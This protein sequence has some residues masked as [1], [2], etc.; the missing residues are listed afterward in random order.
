MIAIAFLA[1][2]IWPVVIVQMFKRMSVERAL[3]WSLMLGY[4]FLPPVIAIDL[5][6][7][8][9]LDK[10]TIP[11]ITAFTCLFM[12]GHK[13]TFLLPNPIARALLIAFV[14]TPIGTVMTNRE[15]ILFANGTFLPG[16]QP[17]DAISMVINQGLHLLPLFMGQAVLRSETALKEL[18]RAFFIGGMIYAIPVLI[19]VRLAPQLNTWIYGFFQHS[20]DQMMRWGGFRP[21][22]FLTHALWVALFILM[23]TLAALSLARNATPQDRPRYVAAAV[24]LMVVLALCK[25]L[26]S[27]VYL[28]MFAPVMLLAT[29]KTMIAI[30]TIIAGVMLLYPILRGAGYVPVDQIVDQFTRINA[31]RAG[32]LAFRLENEGLLLEHAFQ[33]PWFGWGGWDRNFVLD[34]NTG[35]VM[36]IADGQWVIIIGIFGWAGYIV[37]FGLLTL[38]VF[39]LFLNTRHMQNSDVSPWL[40]TLALM[41]GINMLDMLPNATLIPLTWLVCG[42]L[43][44]YLKERE[45]ATAP[46]PLTTAIPVARRTLI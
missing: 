24:F 14:F 39:L 6:L 25:S 28:L 44:G 21:I 43:L 3:I 10:A 35:R 42:A 34:P 12:L 5:P 31:D 27:L 30:A 8:P 16:L 41:H 45:H 9:A 29:R 1:L 33:K 37:E 26:G 40:A 2:F 13:V 18:V 32:S 15:P 38:P 20:F 22:V 23:S 19:E 17:R 7:I 11:A 4:L 46:E 36:T